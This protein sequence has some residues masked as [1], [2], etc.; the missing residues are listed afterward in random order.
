M[1]DMQCMPV[2][3]PEFVQLINSVQVISCV[4]TSARIN[5]FSNCAANA[6]HTT[7]ARLQA[8]A[9]RRAK[10]CAAKGANSLDTLRVA[11]CTMVGY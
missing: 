9:L 3:D 8:V 6:F 11:G 2:A 1:C 7:K 5:T 10:L 4:L